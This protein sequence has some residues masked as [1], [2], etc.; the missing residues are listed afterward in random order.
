[1]DTVKISFCNSNGYS[2]SNVRSKTKIINQ[3][4]ERY[5]LDVFNNNTRIYNDYILDILKKNKYLLCCLIT[6]ARPYIMYFTKIYNDNI[7]LL[8][9]LKIKD[10]FAPNIIAIPISINFDIYNET[11]IQGDLYKNSKTYKWEYQIEK[12]MVYKGRSIN[13]NNQIKNLTICKDI[14][15]SITSNIL[16]PFNICLKEFCAISQIG[17]LVKKNEQQVSGFKIYGL[18]T[19]IM[20]YFNKKYM[21][22]SKYNSVKLIK[23]QLKKSLDSEKMHLIKTFSLNPK[24]TDNDSANLIKII[25]NDIDI[26]KEFVL[27]LKKSPTYGIFEVFSNNKNVGIGRITT[28]ELQNTLSDIFKHKAQIKVSAYYNYNFD[29]W[30]IENIIQNTTA[31]DSIDEINHHIELLKGLSKSNY[32]LENC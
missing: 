25:E 14:A 29:K 9:D 22:K 8:I 16:T 20:Y 7:C 32:V 11:I 18:K 12:C 24:N 13:S 1:M 23:Y 28:I 6:T 31:D 30:N 4:K 17:D 26:E 5:Q 21:P 15:S 19:P 27:T 10:N 3:I 2:I